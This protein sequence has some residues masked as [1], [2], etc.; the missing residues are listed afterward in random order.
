MH[1]IREIVQSIFEARGDFQKDQTNLGNALGMSRQS[2]NQYMSRGKT[3][4]LHIVKFCEDN[5]YSLDGLIT[6]GVLVHRKLKVDDKEVKEMTYIL[7]DDSME[8]LI[9]KGATLLVDSSRDRYSINGIYLIRISD[10]LV[11]RRLTELT[12]N[13]KQRYLFMSASNSDYP[14]EKVALKDIDKKIV[15]RVI[16]ERRPL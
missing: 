14:T 9:Q 12:D 5:G 10:S 3:P 2:L 1:N 6:D 8:P 15:G 13:E 4:W 16:E 7:E 11:V